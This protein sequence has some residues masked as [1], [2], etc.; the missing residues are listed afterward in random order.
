MALKPGDEL[1]LTIVRDGKSQE[2]VGKVE[3]PPRPRDVLANADQLKADAAAIRTEIEKAKVRAD[4]EDMLRLLTELQKGMPAAAAEFKKVY[5]KGNFNVSIHIDV[6]SDATAADPQA[7][8]P[9]PAPQVP[10]TRA[11]SVPPAAAPVPKQGVP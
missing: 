2:L 6:S 5:P 11:S 1:K 7:L 3:P 4:L 10:P 9:A 8:Q